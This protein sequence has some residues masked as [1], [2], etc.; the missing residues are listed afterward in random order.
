MAVYYIVVTISLKLY[1]LSYN[2]LLVPIYCSCCVIGRSVAA[3][4][5]TGYVL[6]EKNVVGGRFCG[7]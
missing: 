2:A 6:D 7:M 3:K 5:I 1:K 4:K